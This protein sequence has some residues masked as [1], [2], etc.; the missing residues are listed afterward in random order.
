MVQVQPWTEL[1]KE[2][3]H[4]THTTP[5]SDS[6]SYLHKLP[7]LKEECTDSVHTKHSLAMSEHFRMITVDMRKTT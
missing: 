5:V 4:K 3:K 6:N 1:Q 7:T 2:Q